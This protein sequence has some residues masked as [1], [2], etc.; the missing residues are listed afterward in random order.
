MGIRDA[1]LGRPFQKYLLRIGS[2]PLE[3]SE[4]L[5]ELGNMPLI[6]YRQVTTHNTAHKQ[7]IATM[8]RATVIWRKTMKQQKE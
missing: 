4:V 1:L 8:E 5:F 3:R 6:A 2:G 7:E